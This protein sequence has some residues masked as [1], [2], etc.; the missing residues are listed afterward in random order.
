MGTTYESHIKK[1]KLVIPKPI[2]NEKNGRRTLAVVCD[3]KLFLYDNPVGK[4]YK[5]SDIIGSESEN[6]QTNE[7]EEKAFLHWASFRRII[8]CSP[9]HGVWIHPSSCCRPASILEG[10]LTLLSS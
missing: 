3:C 4:A 1:S 2:G 9:F 5:A 6:S 7:E 10:K 8:Q